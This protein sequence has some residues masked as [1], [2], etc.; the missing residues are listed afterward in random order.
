MCVFSCRESSCTEKLINWLVMGVSTRISTV[1]WARKVTFRVRFIGFKDHCD[2]V[3][4]MDVCRVEILETSPKTLRNHTRTHTQNK[5]GKVSRA[6]I[7]SLG[8][9]R[10]GSGVQGHPQVRREF[11]P[12][13]TT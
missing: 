8:R 10:K 4:T 5:L 13:W 2:C 9:W 3:F 6:L 7:P 12:G 1:R 11:E